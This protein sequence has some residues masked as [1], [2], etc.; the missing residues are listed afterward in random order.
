[1]TLIAVVVVYDVS[2]NDLRRRIEKVCKSYGLAH[3]QRSVFVG[4]LKEPERR[5]LRVDL[6]NEVEFWEYEGEVSIRI[7]RMPISEYEKRYVIGW[8][9]DYDDD[10]KPKTYEVA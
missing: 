7:F 1:M 9:R 4:F 10:P 6:E 8:L 5:K 2:D 3:I